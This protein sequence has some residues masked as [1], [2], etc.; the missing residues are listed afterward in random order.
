MLIDTP[1]NAITSEIIGS[2]IEVH[3]ILGPGLLES[4]Y[5]QCLVFELAARKLRFV[6]QRAVPIVYKG[7]PLD[8]VYRADLVVEDRI[9]VEVKS[10]A[11]LQPIHQAQLLTYLRLLG[12]PVGLLI[13]FNVPKLTDGVKRVINVQ[14]QME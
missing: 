7:M 11:V 10:A 5:I 4:V 1:Y 2:A 8:G 6:T 13:N 14:V 9:V 12:A 3:R